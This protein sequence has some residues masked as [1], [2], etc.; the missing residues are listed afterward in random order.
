MPT[1]TRSNNNQ[2]RL[3]LAYGT[4]AVLGVVLVGVLAFALP[5]PGEPGPYDASLPSPMGGPAATAPGEATGTVSLA[6]LEI[7]GSHVAMGEVPL[8][9]T[10]VPAWTVHNPTSQAVEFTAGMPQVLEGC[11]PGPVIAD[12]RELAPGDTVAVP[13]SGSVH[14]EFPLQ[15]HDGMGG[16]HHL[17]LPIATPDGEQVTALEVTG[18]FLA[19]ANL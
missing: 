9:V 10:V 2:R 14:L 5:Q 3:R 8:D 17:A 11:C 15:M 19:D 12:G 6:G 7:Q 4:F 18:D 1:T 13:A 16:Y